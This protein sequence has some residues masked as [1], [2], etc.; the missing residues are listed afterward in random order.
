MTKNIIIF[1]IGSQIIASLPPAW[2]IVAVGFCT[3]VAVAYWIGAIEEA[4]V[5][6]RLR[7]LSRRPRHPGPFTGP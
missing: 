6:E 2:M 3:F 4:W 1:L 7:S 5:L